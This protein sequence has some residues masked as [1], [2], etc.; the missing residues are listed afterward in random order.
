V[1]KNK[2]KAP[3]AG[4]IVVFNPGDS[5]QPV[6]LVIESRGIEILVMTPRWPLRWV[7]RDAVRII[8]ES[9]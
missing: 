9:R 6:R 4:D 7:R 2:C 1:L 5:Q 8:N 3:V